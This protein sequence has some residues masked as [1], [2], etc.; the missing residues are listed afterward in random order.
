[1]VSPGHYQ[2][3]ADVAEKHLEPAPRTPPVN[4]GSAGRVRDQT[5]SPPRKSRSERLRAVWKNDDG[6]PWAPKKPSQR[7]V[8]REEYSSEL[9]ACKVLASLDKPTR[10]E[11]GPIEHLPAS[12]REEISRNLLPISLLD[13]VAPAAA[14]TA[15]HDRDHRRGP[16]ADDDE[17]PVRRALFS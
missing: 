2:R 11:R 13:T 14:A 6:E 7:E 8:L 12:V 15:R 5:P 9:Q 10:V 4:S 3:T 17:L 1:M 16:D